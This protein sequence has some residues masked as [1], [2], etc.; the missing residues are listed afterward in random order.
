[1]ISLAVSLELWPIGFGLRRR[2][3][4]QISIRAEIEIKLITQAEAQFKCSRID[5]IKLSS[6]ALKVP[7][8]PSHYDVV[9]V[10][11]L[12]LVVV[13]WAMLQNR[14]L[15]CHD[16]GTA[17]LILPIGTAAADPLICLCLC[18][19]LVLISFLVPRSCAAVL[20][21]NYFQWVGV[22]VCVCVCACA[23]GSVCVWV[24]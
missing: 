17:R 24:C 21:L 11:V 23:Y 19:S 9:A 20:K 3:G 7:T 6:C 13:L 2:K 5:T 18:H 16:N 22:S 15:M 14:L 4:I 1:M 8:Q 10:V 12:V